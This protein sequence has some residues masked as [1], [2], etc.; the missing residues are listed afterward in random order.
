MSEEAKKGNETPKSIHQP[1]LLQEVMEGLDFHPGEHVLDGTVGAAGHGEAI[2]EAIGSGGF[3]IGLDQDADAL[4]RAKERLKDAPA[5]K[6]FSQANFENLEKVLEE[7]GVRH[8]TKILFDLGFSSD[9]LE[10][11]G[12]GFTFQKDEPLGMTLQKAVEDEGQLTAKQ[13]VNDFSDENLVTI[14][15]NYGDER[16]AR[17]IVRGI[18]RA[19]DENPIETTFQLKEIIE[20]S[21]PTMY[22][23][24]RIHP[25]TKTFQALRIAVNNEFQ[26]LQ[27]GLTA[28][29]EH[30]GKDGCVAVISFHSLEDRTVKN[31]FR[32]KKQLGEAEVLTKKPITA[33]PEE[34]QDNP[35]SRSAKLRIARKK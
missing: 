3:Y 30:L 32:E 8:V 2:C 15:K 20:N 7:V 11:S 33:S 10:N 1:V 23:R 13:V 27:N 12:R 29:W 16:F 25:A 6:Y 21:V 5:E 34:L 17:R 9:Q 19:R 26:V 18:V 22:L 35:R 4:Y 24:G 28:A 31:F 14:L